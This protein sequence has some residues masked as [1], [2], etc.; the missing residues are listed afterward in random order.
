MVF[1]FFKQ[2]Y[3]RTRIGRY[4][5]K[6]R[7]KKAELVKKIN[8]ANISSELKKRELRKLGIKVKD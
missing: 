2:Q 1:K 4:Q 3:S 8:Q 5:S 7:L 6:R